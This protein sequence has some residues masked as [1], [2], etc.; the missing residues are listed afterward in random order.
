MANDDGY[1]VLGVDGPMMSLRGPEGIHG[2][3]SSRLRYQAPAPQAQTIA[4][5]ETPV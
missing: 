3:P 2:S 4:R 5:L 1:G